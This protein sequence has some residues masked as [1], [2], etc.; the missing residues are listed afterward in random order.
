MTRDSAGSVELWDVMQCKRVASFP[1]GT[2]MEEVIKEHARKVW[3]PSWFSVDAK[4]GVSAGSSFG[5]CSSIFNFSE[6]CRTN[7]HKEVMSRHSEILQSIVITT[8][9]L[10]SFRCLKLRWTKAMFFRPGYRQGMPASLTSL[11]MPKVCQK[12]HYIYIFVF[13]LKN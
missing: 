11:T 4:C 7:I 8:G 2:N 13:L 12:Q 9:I 3:I 1:E 10:L 6:I 5:W